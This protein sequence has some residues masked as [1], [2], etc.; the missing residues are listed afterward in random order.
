MPCLRLNTAEFSADVKAMF[1]LTVLPHLTCTIAVRGICLGG[2]HSI[3][4]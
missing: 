1:H 4:R 2:V 3:T